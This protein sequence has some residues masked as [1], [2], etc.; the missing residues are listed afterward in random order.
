VEELSPGL[1]QRLPV[2]HTRTRGRHVDYRCVTIAGNQKLA[3]HADA[4]RRPKTDIETRGEGGYVLAPGCPLACHP[5]GKP[6]V[7]LDGDL[8]DIP[9]ITPEE[10]AILLN[11]A[12]TFN[13]YVEP[14]RTIRREPEVSTSQPHGDRP[15]DAYNAR[16]T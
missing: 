6:Y 9:H 8:A 5:L 14:R 13:A 11:A 1:L 12:R 3:Q 10:R 2:I 15:G 7:L 16:V 4:K